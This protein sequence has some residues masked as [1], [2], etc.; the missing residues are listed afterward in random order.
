M[1]LS[2]RHDFLKSWQTFWH[3]DVFLTSWQT[4]GV[5]LTLWQNFWRHDTLLD[6]MTSSWCHDEPFEVMTNMLSSWWFFFTSWT[7]WRQGEIFW[8][9]DVFLAWWRIFDVMTSFLSSW[10]FLHHFVNKII[11]KCVFDVIG[12]MVY[13]LLHDNLLTSWQTFWHHDKLFKV[14]TNLLS[15]WNVFD[16]MTNFLSS[17]QTF[18]RHDVFDIMTNFSTFF[19][20]HFDVLT[21]FWRHN[22]L[23]EVMTCFWLHYKICFYIFLTPWRVFDVMTCFWLHDKLFDI[24]TNVWTS[25]RFLTLWRTFWSNDDLFDIMTYVAIIDVMTN[26]LTPWN[27]LKHDTLFDVLTHFLTSCLSFWR[28]VFFT[29]DKPYDMTYFVINSGTKYDVI[30]SL[31]SWR[32]DFMTNF[33]NH[34]IFLTSWQT[35][36][37]MTYLWLHD[38]LLT[39]WQSFWRHGVFL[40]SWRTWWRHNELCDVITFF[41]IINLTS[42]RLFYVMPNFSNFFL[43]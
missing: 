8:R 35:F 7:F 27:F 26:V 12:I 40:M 1:F 17:W 36:Y 16:I 28:H 43:K 24:M 18:W 19:G 3:H 25:W 31:T 22:E 21:C 4:F 9:N 41:L 2:W 30:L 15:S 13:F 11:W 23:F 14:M 32:H 42:W 6:I 29:Y 34:D 20:E 37:I 10:H 33:L 5:F 38:K 39:L